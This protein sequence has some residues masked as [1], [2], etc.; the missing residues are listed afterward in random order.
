MSKS[1]HIALVAYYW[2]PSGGSGVQRW[3]F[4]ANYFVN[5]GVDVTVFTPKKPRIAETDMT[6]LKKVDPKIH[7]SYVE[8]WE[9]LQNSKKAINENIGQKNGLLSSF[10][11]F[12]RA[13]FFIPDAKVF[14]AKAVWKSFKEHHQAN[15]FDILITTGP[16]HSLHLTGLHAKKFYNLTWIADF[17]DPWVD[18]FQ[19]QSLPLQT[20]AKQKHKRLEKRVVQQANQVVVTAP[21]LEKAFLEQNTRTV[22]ITNGYEN[23]LP[24]TTGSPHGLVYSGSLKAQQNPRNLWYAILELVKE[25]EVFASRFS[26]EIYGNIAETVKNDVTTLKIDHWVSFMDYQ[27]KEQLD[28]I[29]PNAKALLLLGIDMPNAHNVIH[30]KL[31]EYMAAQRPILGIGPKPSDMQ[32]LFDTHNLGVYASFDDVK[33]IKDTLLAWFTADQLSFKNKSTEVFQRNRIAKAYL[34]VI[35]ACE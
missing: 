28:K 31:F 27:S 21:S 23:P 12:I 5:H 35:L 24:K 32:T 3:L 14:W 30:G 19:N 10:M 6:L 25:N 20:F 34:N 15:P 1:K 18:F 9:P 33:L 7:V 22:L 11:R 4:L 29:L 26:L 17:R 2:P 13:N 8:G 16:P